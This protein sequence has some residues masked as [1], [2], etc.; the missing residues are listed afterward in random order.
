[1]TTLAV[2]EGLPPPLVKEASAAA[3]RA[4]VRAVLEVASVAALVTTL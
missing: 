1:M 3:A 2:L 4:E